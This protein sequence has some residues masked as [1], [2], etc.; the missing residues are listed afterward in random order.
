[1]K[2]KGYLWITVELTPQAFMDVYD[3]HDKVKNG[4][5]YCQIAHDVCGLAQAGILANKLIKKLAVQYTITTKYYASHTRGQSLNFLVLK[6][7]VLHHEKMRKKWPPFWRK[8][9][10]TAPQRRAMI[11]MSVRLN[12]AE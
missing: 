6:P 11:N 2:R 3:L 7:K 10:P 1:M 8:S 9:G 4:Y 12:G 5:V